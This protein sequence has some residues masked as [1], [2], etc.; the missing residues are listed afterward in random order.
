[1]SLNM[2]GLEDAKRRAAQ[3][4]ADAAASLAAVNGTAPS[5]NQSSAAS[6]ALPTPSLSGIGG[7][8]HALQAE[9]RSSSQDTAANESNMTVKG[10]HTDDSP[11]SSGVRQVSTPKLSAQQQQQGGGGGNS[12]NRDPAGS[13][14]PQGLPRPVATTV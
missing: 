5:T 10:L 2:Q 3:H 7:P 9:A 12:N 6:S 1:M 8:I 13:P 14:S 4:Q 11:A